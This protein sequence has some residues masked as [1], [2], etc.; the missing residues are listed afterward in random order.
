VE[1]HPEA[2]ELRRRRFADDVESVRQALLQNDSDNAVPDAL[3]RALGALYDAW[4]AWRIT[5][6]VGRRFAT[7]DE[8]VKGNVDGETAAA[9]AFARGGQTHQLIE[10]GRLLGFGLGVYGEG[11][12]GADGWH[13]PTS[14]N[15]ILAV[16]IRLSGVRHNDL[17]V[18]SRPV[19]L[20]SGAVEWGGSDSNRRP[21]DYESPALTS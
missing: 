12:Y 20:S 5:S 13:C 6:G 9:L 1:A 10:F 19:G 3:S 16:S 17:R 4:E 21:R 8:E 7:Q 11:R 2:I 18:V 14:L 15:P